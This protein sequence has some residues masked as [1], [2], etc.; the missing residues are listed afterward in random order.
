MIFSA[1]S[2]FPCARRIL[3]DSG[4]KLPGPKVVTLN[5]LYG[6]RLGNF[7][8]SYQANANS[9]IFA[10]FKTVLK[11]N[12]SRDNQATNGTSVTPKTQVTQVTE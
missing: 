2:T 7:S 3:G 1:L 4:R 8:C 6:N 10:R 9:D 12:H 11:V 5:F